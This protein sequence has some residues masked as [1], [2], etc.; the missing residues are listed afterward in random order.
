MRILFTANPVYSHI[1][2]MLPLAVTALRAGHDVVFATGADA[3]ALPK[4]AGLVTLPAGLTL[5]DARWRYTSAYE[6]GFLAG[7]AA[8]QRLHHLLRHHLAE[9]AAPAL[10]DD[11]IA[12]AATC[13]PDLVIGTPAELGGRIAASV[14][15]VPHVTHGFGP[16]DS[17]ATTVIAQGIL[18]EHCR[19]RGSELADSRVYLDIWPAAM[20]ASSTSLS[21]G[22]RPPANMS[23]GLFDVVWPLRP[24]H[25][26]PTARQRPRPDALA[27]LP[28]KRS[29]YVA[30]GTTHS[31]TPK[32]LEKMIEAL[33]SARLNMLVAIGPGGDL[34]RF[35][36]LP[37]H[38]RIAPS[39]PQETVLPYCD[40]VVCH[41]GS[42]TV[43]G[44]LVHA[45]PLVVVPMAG[46]SHVIAAQVERAGA[47]VACASR[48]LTADAIRDAFL[49]IFTEERYRS[50]TRRI[51]HE[52]LD[53]PRPRSV[54]AR[55]EREF[56]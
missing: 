28:Y 30:L 24:D 41:G 18:G 32:V 53:L 1:T 31:G 45:V 26:V 21:T 56:T 23:A 36:P 55:L 4:E 47:G 33:G 39:I 51:A 25:V 22:T 14:L 52:L 12:F 38:I 44:A 2:P 20:S 17:V 19:R 29:V 13:R 40:A 37:R 48:P 27:S 35:G 49:R 8:E 5:A 16:P 34:K 43:L 46:D 6:P 10:A 9:V 50:S 54:L 15:G 7:L 3:V 42:S 11:A